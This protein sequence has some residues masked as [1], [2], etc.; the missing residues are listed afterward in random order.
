M[1]EIG[2]QPQETKIKNKVIKKADAISESFN[3]KNIIS[4]LRISI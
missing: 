4:P 3:H 2:I 1:E